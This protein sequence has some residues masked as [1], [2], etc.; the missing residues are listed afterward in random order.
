MDDQRGGPLGGSVIWGGKASGVNA[1]SQNDGDAMG[2]PEGL[3]LRGRAC[4]AMTAT[5]VPRPT[6]AHQSPQVFETKSVT[7][8]VAVN[9]AMSNGMAHMLHVDRMDGMARVALLRAAVMPSL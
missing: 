2:V 6:H 8:P 3:G 1:V 5:G 4:H 9:T 7:R